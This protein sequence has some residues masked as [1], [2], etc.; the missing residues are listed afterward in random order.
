MGRALPGAPG[1]RFAS[2]R[3]L[4][5]LQEFINSGS[6]FQILKKCHIRDARP[7]KYDSPA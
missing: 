3:P 1:S 6:G 4:K 7:G 2:F 5:P